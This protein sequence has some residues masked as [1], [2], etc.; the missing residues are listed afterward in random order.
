MRL[1]K[2]HTFVLAALVICGAS[3]SACQTTRHTMV[4]PTQG[5]TVVCA[6]CYDEIRKARSHGGPRGGLA[7]NRKIKVH[8]CD[9]CNTEMS[10][11]SENG[12]LMINCAKCAPA[13]MPCDKCLPPQA[14]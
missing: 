8:M 1:D 3:L 14:N 2:V 10:I 11:Y 7:T 9:D 4:E 5:Q 12:V 13:G 6:K